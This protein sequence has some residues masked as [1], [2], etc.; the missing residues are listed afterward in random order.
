MG[1]I[2]S[3]PLTRAEAPRSL[4]IVIDPPEANLP[5]RS[6]VLIEHV[7]SISIERLGSRIGRVTPATAAAIDEHLRSLLGLREPRRGRPI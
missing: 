4:H 2:V 5:F 3:C 7:R 6:F 1:L